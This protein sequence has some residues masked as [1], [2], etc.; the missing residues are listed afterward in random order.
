MVRG[1]DSMVIHRY[2][3]L[4]P[5]EVMYSAVSQNDEQQEVATDPNTFTHTLV[6]KI[7]LPNEGKIWV[8]LEAIWALL[9]STGNF[10]Y[11]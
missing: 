10:L 3:R 5:S 8:K 9:P 6:T 11:S 4:S 7:L 1:S 2:I